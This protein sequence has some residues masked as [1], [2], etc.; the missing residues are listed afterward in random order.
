MGQVVIPDWLVGLFVF[1]FGCCTGSFLNVVV[2]RLPKGRSIVSPG[3]ACPNCGRPIAWYDN[4]PLVSWL[5]L[6]ARCRYCKVP[7]SVRYIL[8]ELITGLVFLGLYLVYFR[9]GLRR[10]MPG[11]FDGGWLVYI[12]HIVLCCC[13]IVASA[14]DLELWVIPLELCWIATVVGLAGSAVGHVLIDR[15]GL[16]P[17]ASRTTGA[18]TIGGAIGLGIGLLLVR[19]G[20][21]R[22]S[23]EGLAQDQPGP[24]TV[25]HRIEVLY[26]VGFLLPIVV[27]AVL[28][29]LTTKAGPVA[30][31]WGR[32]AARPLVSGLLGSGWGYLVGCG[33]VWVTRIVGTLAF[34]K[35]AMGLGDVHLMGAIGAVLGPT[36]AILAFFIA[37]FLGL[38]W[39][40]TQLLYKKIHEIPYGPFLSIATAVV[41]I[42]HDG[43]LDRLRTVFGPG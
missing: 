9:L 23:Y 15:A 30:G 16:F 11:P 18:I 35:E 13:L 26:E 6:R 22:R 42:W 34:N 37:P 8:I 20:W 1:A 31:I 32:I 38:S 29:W 17:S 5:I 25:R 36:E 10:A 19:R 12:T 7:I 2:Y 33:V 28:A 21:L 43:L 39:A 24:D 41:M 40:A 4:I 14:I 3:S 27:C